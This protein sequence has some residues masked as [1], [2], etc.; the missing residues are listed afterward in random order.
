MHHA[1]GPCIEIHFISLIRKIYK[2]VLKQ[3]K[4]LTMTSKEKLVEEFA[5][6]VNHLI[7]LHSIYI[8][9]GKEQALKSSQ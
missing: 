8:A 6:H 2:F 5:Q 4:G 3:K 7:K 1:V 9:T